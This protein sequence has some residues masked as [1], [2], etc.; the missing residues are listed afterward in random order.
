MV[1]Y[2][3]PQDKRFIVIGMAIA[4]YPDRH[5]G[6]PYYADTMVLH[7]KW[8]ERWPDNF[9][10]ITPILQRHYDPNNPTDVQN[11]IDGC[12]PSSLRQPNDK[13]HLDD[14]GQTIVTH[15]VYD[16]IIQRGW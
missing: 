13:V 4:D 8:R 11:V 7:K 2:L 6:T 9:I 1:D 14:A 10:D 16:H 12:T 3:R 15:A 5:K